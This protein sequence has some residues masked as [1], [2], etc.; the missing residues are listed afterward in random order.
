MGKIAFCPTWASMMRMM[1]VEVIWKGSV[2]SS[3]VVPVYEKLVPQFLCEHFP[4]KST[5]EVESSYVHLKACNSMY[6][7]M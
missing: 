6:M 4:V 1:V 2:E 3:D 7:Y 5:L